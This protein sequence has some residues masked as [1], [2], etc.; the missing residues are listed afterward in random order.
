MLDRLRHRQIG[1]V[2]VNVLTDEGNLEPVLRGMNALQQFL[3]FLP[4]HVAEGQS[5]SLDKVG[6]E[7]LAMQCQRHVVDRRHVGTLDNRVAV[8]VAHECNLRL[9]PFGQRAIGAQHQRVRRDANR[10][11]RTDGVLRR[12]RLELTG[13]R[14]ERNER[15][16]HK[17]DVRASEVVAHLTGCLEEGLRFDVTNR[18]A[19]FGDDDVGAIAVL[20]GL[21]LAPHHILNL[22]SN[23]RNNLNGIAQILAAA[24]LSDNRGVH[25]ACRRICSA[26]QVHIQE[27]FVVADIEIGF[28]AILRHE[29]LAVLE[30]IHR[31]GI[32]IDV[33]IELLHDH[34][35]SPGAKQPTQAGGG[36]ALAQR[37]HNATRDKNMLGHGIFRTRRAH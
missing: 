2:Q 36:Q 26:R 34:M 10:P 24:F 28:R 7:A 4:V 9:D 16:V 31:A 8:N 32:D 35:Q 20:V 13:C 3:P 25:L 6:V 22:V 19:N 33:G 1:V 15:H 21:R 37:G 23:M 12:L 27:A 5:E 17:G 11:Q 18:A 29:N 14:Q 30:G